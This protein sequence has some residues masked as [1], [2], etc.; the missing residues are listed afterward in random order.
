MSDLADRKKIAAVPRE[1]NGVGPEAPA[2]IG[3]GAAD[4]TDFTHFAERVLPTLRHLRHAR[5]IAEALAGEHASPVLAGIG[6]F[7]LE[8]IRAIDATLRMTGV[9]DL[10][11]LAV[12]ESDAARMDA[13]CR[14]LGEAD[15]RLQALAE[16]LARQRQHAGDTF[17]T[18]NTEPLHALLKTLTTPLSPGSDAPA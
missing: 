8:S 15:E 10:S 6:R 16:E 5:R 4:R 17:D 2:G 13:V 18:C 9:Y 14:I 12:L 1:K 7:A 11:E 3:D